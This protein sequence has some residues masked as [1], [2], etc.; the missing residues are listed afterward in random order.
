MSLE[1]L[2]IA[3]DVLLGTI[4]AS[5]V[6]GVGLLLMRGSRGWRDRRTESRRDGA[7]QVLMSLMM[8]EPDEVETAR[9]TISSA[10][11]RERA[12]LRA[13][14]FQLLTKV[15]GE[16]ADELR[17]MLL[18]DT[19]SEDA[20]ALTRSRSAVRRC[21]GIHR[22]GLLRRA[23]DLPVMVRLL[24]DKVFDVRRMAVRALGSLGHADAASPLVRRAGQARLRRD[25]L[26]ALSR[27]GTPAAPALR[28]ELQNGLTRSSGPGRAAELSAHALGLLGDVESVGLLV[29]GL[30]S[31]EV[32]LMV[33]C[34][35]ALGD[36]G[37][38]G[39]VADLAALL[40]HEDREARTAAATA[41]GRIGAPEAVPALAATF[42]DG[43]R[44][45]NR[46]VATALLRIGDAG[47]QA[48]ASCPSPYAREALAVSEVR[49][50]A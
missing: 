21:R 19:A 43:D 29:T 34:A 17:R 9:A 50:I 46:A 36:I 15:R 42:D 24:D 1:I 6:L 20:L 27:L 30:R 28:H 38:P 37:A 13:E 47:R 23:E 45:L 35:N 49:G 18:A 3:R 10:T 26:V 32:R 14:A 8:G 39:S 33:R 16:A 25:L 40:G 5:A 2:D 44:V 22:L 11:R 12:D 31:G 41:L 7:R 48:L 4:V